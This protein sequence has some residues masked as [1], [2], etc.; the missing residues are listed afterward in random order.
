MV[1]R[2]LGD[3]DFALADA[4]EALEH[5]EATGE[6]RRISIVQARLA[7]VLR[8]RGEFAEADRLFEEA[9]SVELPTRLRAEIAE[10]AGR[11]AFDQGRYLEAMNRFDQ[12]LDL[13]RGG[14]DGT[15]GADRARAGLGGRVR[16][17][18][19]L[20]AVSAK[21]RRDPTAPGAAR[22]SGGRRA[23]RGGAALP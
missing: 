9:D 22:T 5:A 16:A 13:R 14:D 15:G 7:N 17:G 10:L 20:G 2:V 23:L 4:R 6:L 19:G 11:S 8:W 1:S 12:A 3:L 21:C 18:A